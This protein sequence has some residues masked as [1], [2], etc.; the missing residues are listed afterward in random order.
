MCGGGGGGGF[1]VHDK[2]LC[3]GI[4]FSLV[5][6]RRVLILFHKFIPIL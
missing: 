4:L 1:Y 2:L 5:L 6:A 3:S